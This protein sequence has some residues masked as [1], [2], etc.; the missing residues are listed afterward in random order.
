MRI[1]IEA[2]TQEIEELIVVL[3]NNPQL[4][5]IKKQLIT[6]RDQDN[7]EQSAEIPAEG[8]DQFIER[9]E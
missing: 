2:N 4:A 8:D 1:E 9:S 3:S 6:L 7:H 5:N